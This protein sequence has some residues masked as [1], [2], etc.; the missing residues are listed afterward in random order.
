MH[1]NRQK[2]DLGVNGHPNGLRRLVTWPAAISLVAGAAGVTLLFAP[3]ASAATYTTF[4][5][6]STQVTQGSNA[7]GCS[8]TA[9]EEYTSDANEDRHEIQLDTNGGFISFV[10][11]EGDNTD[12]FEFD[13]VAPGMHQVTFTPPVGNPVVKSISCPGATNS[14]PVAVDDTATTSENTAVTVDVLANDS[15]PDGDS[16]TVTGVTQ[17]A[18]GTAAVNGN[19]TVYTPA[20]DYV[21]T[22]SYTYTISDG[23]GGTDTA[24]VTV[25]VTASTGGSTLTWTGNGSANANPGCA[26]G[27]T[28]NWHWILTPGGTNTLVSGTLYVTYKS[29]ATTTSNGTVKSGGNGAM[30]FYPSLPADDTV[31]SAYVNYTYNGDGKGN[32]VLT[33]SDSS[34]TPGSG[35]ST[36]PGGGQS[37][38]P[39]GG[40]SST[41]G[42]GQSST[43]GGGKTTTPGGGHTTTPGGHKPTTPGVSSS[44]APPTSIGPPSPSRSVVT[45]VPFGNTGDFNLPSSGGSF[46]WRLAGIVVLFSVAFGAG[47]M[48]VSERFRNRVVRTARRVVA[49]F[50][51]FCT[52]GAHAR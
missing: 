22:D 46:N 42:G 29:G 21:G 52:P 47:L 38:T 25:T 33:I 5:Y 15:D 3:P 48:T 20:T 36:T 27:Q 8:I 44:I 9:T 40:Q 37:S 23:N 39:G 34:C 7:S 16:L 13:G 17:P 41:P 50:R 28:A 2:K 30:H 14:P 51:A 10:T 43:P 4:T 1:R 24:T 12:S 11:I 19:K 45:G 35:D 49:G 18:H 6:V 32:F 26:S 31:V